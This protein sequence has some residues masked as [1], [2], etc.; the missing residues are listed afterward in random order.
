MLQI[1]F[2]FV[3]LL[4]LGSCAPSGDIAST[5]KYQDGI[6]P[7]QTTSIAESEIYS[8]EQEDK[9][10]GISKIDI[11]EIDLEVP[12]EVAQKQENQW[13]AHQKEQEL[14]RAEKDDQHQSNGFLSNLTDTELFPLFDKKQKSAKR[15]SMLIAFENAFTNGNMMP[16]GMMKKKEAASPTWNQ[17]LTLAIVFGSIAVVSIWLAWILLAVLLYPGNVIAFII[18]LSSFIT[19]G[20]L[21]IVN[22]VK[23]LN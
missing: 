16:T 7:S 13:K 2:L 21:G 8:A 11:D 10:S 18:F 15:S 23:G 22:L 3:C 5:H 1:A 12:E 20:V 17:N 4:F 14:A 19:F 9:K 6:Q